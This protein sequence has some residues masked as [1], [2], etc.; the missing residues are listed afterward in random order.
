M[1]T[2]ICRYSGYVGLLLSSEYYVL[3]MV[4]FPVLSVY[5]NDP[6]ADYCIYRKSIIQAC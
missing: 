5:D 1:Y 2:V 4:D 3:C 6:K